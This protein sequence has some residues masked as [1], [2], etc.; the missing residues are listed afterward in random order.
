MIFILLF[1]HKASVIVT[2]ESY[3]TVGL[4]AMAAAGGRVAMARITMGEP[5]TGEP[6]GDSVAMA[7]V[8][9]WAVALVFSVMRLMR[10]V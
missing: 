2:V 3:F 6:L 1:L 7:C 4:S 9:C 8:L 5:R 10:A